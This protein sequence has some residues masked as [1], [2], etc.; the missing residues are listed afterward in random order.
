MAVSL[1][2]AIMGTHV[3]LKGAEEG[4]RK[5]EKMAEE[6]AAKVAASFGVMGAAISSIVLGTVVVALEKAIRTTAE[7][8]L[9]MEHL[10]NRMGVTAREAA[11][12]TGVMERFGVNANVG[13][14]AMQMLSTQVRQ[15]QNSLDPFQTRLGQ[16]LGTLRDTS[17]NAL[18]MAQVL[19]LV[20]QKVSGAATDSEKLQIA[21][22]LL[23]SRIG[24]Q[25]VPMLKLSND[26]WARQ[27]ASVEASLGPVEKA[28]ELAL[29]YKQ[30]T[31]ELEQSFRGLQVELGT[32]LLP[33]II[34]LV[35]SFT[36]LTNSFRDFKQNHPDVV[37]FIKPWKALQVVIEEVTKAHIYAA[38]QLGLVDKGTLDAFKNM[39]NYKEEAR[40]ASLEQE[41]NAE[42]SEKMAAAIELTA[43]NEKQ[44]VASV[45]ERVTLL[46]K[47]KALGIDQSRGADVQA[48][49]ELALGKFEEER[50]KLEDRLAQE[51]D[52]NQRII[53]ETEIMKIRVEAAK[54]AQ[55]TVLSGYKQEE[56]LLKARG[57]INISTE[58]ELLQKKLG[59]E[60]ILGDERLKIEAELYAKRKQYA[61]E[62]IKVARQLG[63]ASVDQEIAYRKQKAAEALGKGDVI[64]AAQEVVKARDLA[65]QQADMVMEFTKKIRIVSLQSEIEYQKQKLE[66]VKGNAEQEIKIL[67]DIADKDKKLYD[68]RLAFSLSYTQNVVSQ[69]DK[70]MKAAKESGETETYEY[71]RVQ[72]DRQLVE[73]T[74][75]AGGVLRG[76]GTAGQRQAAVEFAQFVNKQIE[77]MQSMGKEVSGIWRDAA[78]VAKDILKAAS[79][80]EEVRA[81]GG[82]SPTIGSLLSPMEGLATSGLARGTDIPRLDTSFTDLAIRVRDVIL[83]TI[84]N[85]QSFSNAVTAAAAKIAAVTGT[86]FAPG[87]P[88]P[89]GNVTLVPTDGSGL[90][91]TGSST[92]AAPT[93]GPGSTAPAQPTSQVGI[94]PQADTT[95]ILADA[96]AALKDANDF[97]RS[98]QLESVAR[99][100]AS[101]QTISDSL[102]AAIASHSQVTIGIDSNTGDLIV[103]RL[104]QEL[105][106]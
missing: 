103:T 97:S 15:T 47:A 64:G 86:S 56:L 41:K 35:H 2:E 54:L 22:Q 78:G 92:P 93:V 11:V 13:A 81:P 101:N 25:L 65:L 99:I 3:D 105:S 31:A 76:G 90:P 27:K 10:A 67:S 71:A 59:D 46:E 14:R 53:K 95:R 19:D 18:N 12:L 42:E 50:K 66:L 51:V 60:H 44:L 48:G 1:L 88:G 16:V 84:P 89:G 82:P 28:A 6:A 104:I 63:F 100:E 49:V 106:Q 75:E 74:R 24:G 23:G 8:G 91:A 70:I 61:E 80:G 26:E 102:R 29:A 30:A 7:W 39:D 73:A 43:K 58:I 38:E 40:K 33:T 69:Y 85:I 4:L 32:Q 36:S 45:K 52:P 55:D 21:T 68:D 87:G 83:G 62:A 77:Q 57:A 37:E 17:G 5:F 20:R 96:V 79:G 34:D 94:G 98:T 72:S 9:E